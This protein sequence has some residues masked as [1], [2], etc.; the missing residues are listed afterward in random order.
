MNIVDEYEKKHQE[1]KEIAGKIIGVF[2]CPCNLGVA[3]AAMVMCIGTIINEGLDSP[4]D[5]E[6]GINEI[7]ENLQ[8]LNKTIKEHN[9]KQV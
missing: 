5:K 7:I 9:T 8:I 3:L 4:S 2:T 6:K 1:A